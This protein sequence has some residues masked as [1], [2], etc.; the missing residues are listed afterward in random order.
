MA[1][2]WLLKLE[3]QKRYFQL[4]ICWMCDEQKIVN[5]NGICKKCAEPKKENKK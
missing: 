3:K 1:K 4:R 5:L 2:L